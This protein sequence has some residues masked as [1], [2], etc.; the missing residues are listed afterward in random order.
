MLASYDVAL[1]RAS[2]DPNRKPSKGPDVLRWTNDRAESL[3]PLMLPSEWTFD[4]TNTPWQDIVAELT[5]P[6]VSVR[7]GRGS[8]GLPP[9]SNAR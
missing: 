3:I 5:R 8:V 2:A 9:T 1:A 4:T 6:T 7:P